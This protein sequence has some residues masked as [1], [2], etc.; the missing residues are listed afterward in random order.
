V[1]EDDEALGDEGE[2][3]DEGEPEGAL[4]ISAFES[5]LVLPELLVAVTRQVMLVPTSSLVTV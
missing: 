1:G 2:G 4:G 5:A 3:D